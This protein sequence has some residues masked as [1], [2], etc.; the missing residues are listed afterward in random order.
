MTIFPLVKPS[1]EIEGVAAT[2]K[3]ETEIMFAS[4]RLR[5]LNE[6][7]ERT[8]QARTAELQG[9]NRELEA[10]SYSVA[11]D[12]RGPLQGMNVFAELLRAECADKL[13]DAA[14]DYLHQ[15][16]ENALLMG[17]LIEAL[18]SLANVGRSQLRPQPI[19]LAG[20]ARSVAGKL[21]AAQADRAVEMV[22]AGRLETTMDPVLALMLIENLVDNAW[23]FTRK[24]P[25][26][27]V[28]IGAVDVAGMRAF[29]VR[30]NGA[31]FDMSL[32]DKLFTAFQRLH[33]Q[34]EFPGTGIGLATCHRIVDR[35]GGRI[36]AEGR[37]GEGATIFFTLPT[38]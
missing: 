13:G 9:V 30:D 38:A 28:E 4:E 11:H 36:W 33:T 24:T 12:L 6:N 32:A 15:I 22:V 16:K 35:H 37:V 8:V 1:G 23:K 14:R 18:L 20:L 5:E 17:R 26:A 2:Y 7:L 19:D 10:F 27:R 3:D 25:A 29:F 31:G 34:S 21:A